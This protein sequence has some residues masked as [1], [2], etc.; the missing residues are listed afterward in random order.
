M[1][2]LIF[3]TEEKQVL[4]ATDT[5]A[6]SLDGEPLK[7]TTKAFIIPHLRMIMAGTGVMG[8]LGKWFVKVNDWII[9]RDIDNLDYHTPRNL[10]SMWQSFKQEFPVKDGLTTTVYHFGFSQ[11]S[12]EINTYVYRS[13]NEFSSERIAHG[14]GAKPACSIPENYR[15][16][17]DIKQMMDDQ[18]L[19]QQSQPS[20]TRVHI[21]G[22]IQ[23][24]QLSEDGF[25]TYTL[26][27]FDDYDSVQRGIFERCEARKK[28]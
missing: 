16:P 5:L 20:D 13:T 4:V 23:V 14:L 19:R 7:Y 12:G 27:R 21:G 26:D 18:R 22:E 8:F 6:T 15:M 28:Q 9:V 1:S 10:A 25:Y 2:S 3:H 11:Q 24:N 17:D